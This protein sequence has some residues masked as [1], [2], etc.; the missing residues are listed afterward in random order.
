[1]NSRTRRALIAAEIRGRTLRRQALAR[2]RP[3]TF[4][5]GSGAVDGAQKDPRGSRPVAARV[6]GGERFSVSR[7]RLSARRLQVEVRHGWS[8]ALDMVS[9]PRNE[10]L[11]TELTSRQC[12]DELLLIINYGVDLEAVEQ[13][14]RFHR[15]MADALVPVN[16]RMVL[17][18]GKAERGCLLDGGRVQVL[19]TKS[20][21]R[22]RYRGF[23]GTQVAQSRRSA[24]LLDDHAVQVQHLGK[25]QIA[26]SRKPTVQLPILLQDLRRD[27]LE[28]VPLPSNQVGN[29]SACQPLDGD[30][31]AACLFLQSLCFGV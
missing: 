23:E 26:H 7:A 6:R 5:L 4:L 2:V 1:M 28:V 14:K 11:S 12:E 19:A 31:E 3:L 29:R 25:R 17:H 13:E 22:L 15:G 9:Q 20:H 8:R 30:P 21:S 10:L 27:R 16:E 24:C 18:E